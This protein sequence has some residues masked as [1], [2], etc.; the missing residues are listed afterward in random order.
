MT[1]EVEVN[2]SGAV[3]LHRQQLEQAF[4]EID[5]VRRALPE[6]TLVALAEEVVARLAQN[7]VTALAPDLVPSDAEIDRLC[8]D[9]L[10]D[11]PSAAANFIEKA[12]MRGYDFDMLC[13]RYLSVAAQRLGLW[14]EQDRVSFYNVTIAAGRIYAILRMLRMKRAYHL[15]DMRRAAVFA[16]VPGENH[17]LGITM[18]TDMARE[19]GW[20]IE[21]FVG[22]SH[23]ELLETLV[24]RQ[25]SIIALSAGGK[26]VLPA[27]GRLIVALHISAPAAQILVCGQFAGS[28]L[29]PVG[30]AGADAIALD[31]EGALKEMERFLILPKTRDGEASTA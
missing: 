5:E 26:R 17:T 11:D 27:L 20:D 15:P 18:A 30:V 6:A 4:S 8:G 22:L 14:W 12:Q 9:L 19:R 13:N 29:V 28:G 21:L 23:E 2:M 10:S 31:F 24:S 3:M 16:S 7:R 1:L 25:P